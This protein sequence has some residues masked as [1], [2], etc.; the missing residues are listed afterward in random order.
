[1]TGE[2]PSYVYEKRILR[3]SG[4]MI[5]VRASATLLSDGDVRAAQIV[6]LVEDIDARKRA[7]SM[8]AAKT[9]LAELGSD[10]SSALTQSDSLVEALQL[11]AQA[12][13]N[14]LDATLARV[15]TMNAAGTVLE[16]EAS[17]GMHSDLND[18]Q[19]RI[20]VGSF[21]I[22][23]IAKERKPHLT[24]DIA[25]DESASDRRWLTENG[26][27][28][29]AGYP[30]IVREKLVGVMGMYS[31][32][33]LSGET[34]EALA[35]VANSVAIGIERKKAEGAL[36]RQWLLF[37]T[38]LSNTPDFAYTF[39]LD[40]RFTYINR[41]LLTLLQK[42]LDEAL[43]KNFFDLEYPED[44]AARL[45]RQIQP[46]IDTRLPLRDHTPFTD[47]AGTT[48]HYEYIFVPVF[49]ADGEV[50]AVAGST[51]DVTDNRRSEEKL[52]QSEERLSF[53]LAAGGGVGTWDWNIPEDRVYCNARFAD[54]FSIDPTTA[55]EGA[56][57]SAFID[58][59]HP[60]DRVFVK[61][62]IMQAMSAGQ[63]FAADRW[64]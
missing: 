35:S 64:P 21:E 48:G 19:A 36:R 7:E 51:R 60:N 26:I 39:D 33:R 41:A 58:G 49:S 47:P 9:R 17:S 61:D 30:L 25:N 32:T 59:I 4:E 14:H 38:V 44:L 52:R 15:W 63:D 8:V 45:Q 54:V 34:L 24:N 53:A 42:N 12:L 29:F 6:G 18:A 56:P 1:V 2:I 22:G 55:A 40:G 43:G 57:L 16:L 62:R 31:Q 28:A 27:V 10:S 20:P 50:E 46:V 23:L 11:C 5:W 37:D 3:K 13:V